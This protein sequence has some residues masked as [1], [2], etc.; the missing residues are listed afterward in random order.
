MS[1]DSSADVSQEGMRH[2][3]TSS[4]ELWRRTRVI[5]IYV[6]LVIL[7]GEGI[8]LV[9]HHLFQP[10]YVVVAV[11]VLLMAGLIFWR[12]RHHY[13]A[14]GPD[15]LVV[16]SNFRTSQIPY[17]Q[18]R[19]SRCQPLR[20]FFEAPTRR[21]LLTGSLRRYAASPV[22][23]VRVEMEPS[24]LLTFGRMLGRRTVL[25]Q[26]LILIVQDPEQLD[27]G[28]QLRIRRRPPAPAVRPTRRRR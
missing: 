23:I 16:R 3:V 22:C 28:L 27:R 20:Q 11:A 14:L 13:V 17:S 24:E 2:R 7:V 25:D 19:Q 12:Q 21:E 26:D 15:G 1:G 9:E 18:V 4:V 10:S 6:A 8:I 5:L